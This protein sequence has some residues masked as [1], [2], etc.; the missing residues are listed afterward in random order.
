MSDIEWIEEIQQMAKDAER[1]RKFRVAFDNPDNFI[2]IQIGKA[3]PETPEELDSVIDA[4]EAAD[5]K[6]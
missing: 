3:N 6:P 5:A 4:T 2:V 1:Y